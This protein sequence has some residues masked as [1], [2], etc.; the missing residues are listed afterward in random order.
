MQICIASRTGPVL[1][2]YCQTCISCMP[3]DLPSGVD[4]HRPDEAFRARYR[5]NGNKLII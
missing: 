4:A 3:D 2:A 1:A 5:H